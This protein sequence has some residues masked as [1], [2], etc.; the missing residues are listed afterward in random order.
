LV[1]KKIIVSGGKVTLS[2]RTW[3]IFYGFFWQNQQ[4]SP[5]FSTKMQGRIAVFT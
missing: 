5:A 4:K 2:T 1:D 3:Q